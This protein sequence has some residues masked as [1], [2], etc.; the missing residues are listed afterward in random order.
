MKNPTIISK[1]K[2]NGKWVCQKE[3]PP[4]AVRKM[5]EEVMIRAGGNIGFDVTPKAKT[6]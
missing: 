6:A 3:V 2:I 5:V 1:L 4:E